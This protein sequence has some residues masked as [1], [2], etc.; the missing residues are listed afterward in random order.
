MCFLFIYSLVTTCDEPCLPVSIPSGT[1]P[2]LCQVRK[3]GE[4]PV[5]S[6]AQ[7][8]PPQGE[9]SVVSAGQ[10]GEQA[11]STLRAGSKIAGWLTTS[12][13]LVLGLILPPPTL[14]LLILFLALTPPTL[15]SSL[16]LGAQGPYL[17]LLPEGRPCK[18]LKAHDSPA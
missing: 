9:R 18:A 6:P 12:D 14:G 7:S 4:Q 8:G 17:W 15:P 1:N 5:L 10:A 16:G 2:L 13:F 3:T 11:L